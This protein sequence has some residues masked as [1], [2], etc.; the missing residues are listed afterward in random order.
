MESE[1][2]RAHKS[3]PLVPILGQFIWVTTITP[4]VFKIHF[5]IVLLFWCT[6]PSRSLLLSTTENVRI[7]MS[8]V[9]YPCHQVVPHLVKVTVTVTL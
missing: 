4:C 1:D 2:Y 7:F 9:R 8:A 6:S 5:N 3:P